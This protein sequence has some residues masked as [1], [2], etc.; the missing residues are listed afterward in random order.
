MIVLHISLVVSCYH[1]NR[2]SFSE[3][4]AFKCYLDCRFARVLCLST[5]KVEGL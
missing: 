2:R 5:Y 3:M 4:L 1:K